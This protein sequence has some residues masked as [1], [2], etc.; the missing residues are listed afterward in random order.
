[1]TL[2]AVIN[3]EKTSQYTVVIVD[4]EPPALAK[5]RRLLQ[6]ETDINI[7]GEAGDGISALQITE[8]LQPDIVFLDIQMPELD[9]LAV[10]SNLCASSNTK[11][12]FVTGFNE[13]A[14]QAFELNAVDYLLKP[15]NRQRLHKTL[16]RIRSQ[17]NGETIAIQQKLPGLIEQYRSHQQYPKQLMFKTE[18]GIQLVNAVDLEWAETSGNYV[19]VC[20]TKTAF[21][22][23]ITLVNL[24]SQLDPE[25]FIRIHRSHLVNIERIEKLVP[26]SKGDHQVVLGNA[27]ELRLSRSYAEAFFAI[28]KGS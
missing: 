22:A 25:C 15:Y 5:L 14:I 18:Q 8:Q 21:I 28:F 16:D 24:L 11:V 12:V 6:S 23:R 26:L 4:D 1:M 9:G 19:K 3:P 17:S 10:A 20:T 27:V 7:I 2:E 13:Y